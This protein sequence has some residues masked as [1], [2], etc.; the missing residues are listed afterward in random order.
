MRAA[1]Y[2]P[3]REAA[4][5]TRKL[6]WDADQ[7]GAF[8]HKVPAEAGTTSLIPASAGIQ[9]D[10]LHLALELAGRRG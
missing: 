6:M 1:G 2:T 3:T 10:E 8:A 4:L 7:A 9:D 5:L